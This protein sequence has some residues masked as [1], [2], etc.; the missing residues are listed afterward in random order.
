[1]SRLVISLLAMALSLA[2]A[3]APATPRAVNPDLI[4][5]LL[6]SANTSTYP[7]TS[8][9]SISSPCWTGRCCWRTTAR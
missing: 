4:F 7:K 2:V 3:Q 6:G 9:T 1:M 8:G 5:V